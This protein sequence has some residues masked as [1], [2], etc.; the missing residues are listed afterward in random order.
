MNKIILIA[1]ILSLVISCNDQPEPTPEKNA[2]ALSATLPSTV[3]VVK[4]NG[5]SLF[6]TGKDTVKCV[7]Y[8]KY[9]TI[10]HPYKPPVDT[11]TRKNLMLYSGFEGTEPFKTWKFEACRL[12]ETT[13]S[14][15]FAR[16]GKYSYRVNLKKTDI[17]DPPISSCRAEIK[18]P[19]EKNN[20]E[21]WYGVSFYLPVGYKADP[22]CPEVIFQWHQSVN[23][24]KPPPLALWSYGD[25]F[26]FNQ[27]DIANGKD[28]LT[29]LINTTPGKWMDVVFH[30]KFSAGSDG[31][32]EIWINGTKL[33]TKTGTNNYSGTTGNDY[34]KTGIYKWGWKNG[35]PSTVSERILYIDEIRIGN[36]KA[37]YN[38][39][40]PG[41]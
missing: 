34:L 30:I 7:T 14:S 27:Y 23:N 38:D 19:V 21:R 37:T 11:T 9:D 33:Y 32:V 13:Q 28:K 31:L 26:S 22:Q 24:G 2:R 40:K 5:D 39:V 35:Y 41:N 6:I 16:V 20:I 36:E 1:A 3:I 8:T 18:Q 17:C 29:K 10:T 25:Y 15:D 4:D 12:D